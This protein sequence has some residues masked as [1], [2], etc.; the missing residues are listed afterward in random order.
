M[1]K[2]STTGLVAGTLPALRYIVAKLVWVE[3]LKP[4]GLV[5]KAAKSIVTFEE[6][7]VTLFTEKFQSLLSALFGNTLFERAPLASTT[8]SSGVAPE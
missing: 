2:V 3:E 1:S 4:D 8:L 5:F 6:A 7:R